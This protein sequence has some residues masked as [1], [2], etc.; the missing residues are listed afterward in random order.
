MDGSQQINKQ[1]INDLHERTLRLIYCDHSSNFQE[2]L[3]RD[4]SVTKIYIYKKKLK[5]YPGTYY[6]IRPFSLFQMLTIV[7]KWLSV[8][9]TICE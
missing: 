3:Q 2:L 8:S 9:S 7:K 6:S 4:N 1:K 5:K